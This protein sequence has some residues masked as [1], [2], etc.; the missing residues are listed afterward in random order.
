VNNPTD[1]RRSVGL[2]LRGEA[3]LLYAL[4]IDLRLGVG[5]ALDPLPGRGRTRGYFTIGQAF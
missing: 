5:Q 2:E 3:K 4:A 1:Y